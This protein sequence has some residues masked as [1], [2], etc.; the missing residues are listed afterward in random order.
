MN[1]SAL[2]REARLTTVNLA[3]CAEVREICTVLYQESGNSA[4]TFVKQCFPATSGIKEPHSHVE[5]S[6]GSESGFSRRWAATG[7]G[8]QSRLDSLRAHDAHRDSIAHLRLR[9]GI[10]PSPIIPRRLAWTERCCAAGTVSR[11]SESP[12]SRRR[13]TPASRRGRRGQLTAAG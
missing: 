11:A 9:R 12:R 6:V 13:R 7:D 5:P 2:S 4:P 8:W 3:P 10:S 1:A